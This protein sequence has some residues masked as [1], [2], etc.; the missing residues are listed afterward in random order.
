MYIYIVHAFFIYVYVNKCIGRKME[1][2]Y[3]YICNIHT[4]FLWV[5]A[6][7]E[8]TPAEQRSQ[9]Y[10]TNAPRMVSPW[11]AKIASMRVAPKEWT[12][13]RGHDYDEY[14]VAQ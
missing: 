13:P 6:D 4:H 12:F 7:S 2:T 14:L 5:H 1:N 11:Q 8:G 10:G 3:I 9:G